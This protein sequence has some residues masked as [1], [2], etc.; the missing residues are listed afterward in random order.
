MNLICFTKWTPC[1]FMKNWPF[2]GSS[3][4]LCK[5]PPRLKWTD[6][7][8]ASCPSLFQKSLM[9]T[10]LMD[11]GI[12]LQAPNAGDPGSITGQGT[13]SHMLQLRVPTTRTPC[14]QNKKINVFFL[15]NKQVL[16]GQE[17]MLRSLIWGRWPFKGWIP[18][19]LLSL[20]YSASN[21]ARGWIK[22]RLLAGL[23]KK[24]W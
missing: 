10:S 16:D 4:H 3:V 11:Q 2:T 24:Y 5:L 14:S 6:G 1:P 9:G 12:R 19:F 23:N 15:N 8:E 7:K 17:M 22:E 20:I 21:S 18:Y 13:W